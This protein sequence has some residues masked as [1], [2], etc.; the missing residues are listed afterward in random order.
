MAYRQLTAGALVLVALSSLAVIQAQNL[1]SPKVQGACNARFNA[2][3]ATYY[4]NNQECANLIFNA[5][6]T[7]VPARCPAGGTA[8]GSPVHKCM[9]NNNTGVRCSRQ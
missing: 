4:S 8:V 5:F 6:N 3:L 9:N 7:T 2:T 1:Q